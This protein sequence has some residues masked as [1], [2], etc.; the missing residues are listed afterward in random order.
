MKKILIITAT[1][2]LSSLALAL[3][4]NVDLETDA[5]YYNYIK[6][7]A[8]SEEL[9]LMQS[10]P[11]SVPQALQLSQSSTQAFEQITL[12]LNQELSNVKFVFDSR[13]YISPGVESIGYV[14]D[15]AYFSYTNDSFVLYT[16]KQRIKWGTGYS[17]NPTDLLQPTKDLLEPGRY[18]EGIYALRAEYSNDFITPSLIISPD[19]QALNTPVAQNYRFALQLY[20][21]IGTADFFLNSIYQYQ[22]LQTIGSAISWDFGPAILNLE[23]A[24]VRYINTADNIRTNM[25]LDNGATIQYN[26][27]A[28]VQKQ[29]TQDTFLY[30]EYFRNNWGVDNT[31]YDRMY[32]MAQTTPSILGLS[33]LVIKKDYGMMSFSYNWNDKLTLAIT[34]I[35]G[36][37]D[38]MALVYPQIIWLE[39][40]G[41]DILLGYLQNCTTS[42]SGEGQTGIPIYNYLELRLR[43]YL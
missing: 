38:G 20:K 31:E 28:G 41:F 30:I 7:Q 21:L 26:W 10:A 9:S 22:T 15:N 16:G 33:Q 5:L 13:F 11:A 39:N 2:L 24:A 43:A 25:G 1:V 37:D 8:L 36:M 32:S 12:K 40:Q 19:T 42:R 23:G 18:L 35:Y 34:G 4:Y 14:I 3:D 27:L 17:W 29:I 6:N